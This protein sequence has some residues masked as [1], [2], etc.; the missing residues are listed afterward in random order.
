MRVLLLIAALLVFSQDARAS[1][2]SLSVQCENP[3]KDIFTYYKGVAS[4]KEQ[5][6]DGTM[7]PRKY[8]LVGFDPGLLKA[9]FYTV[10]EPADAVGLIT[11]FEINFANPA[12]IEHRIGP[13]V[14]V[15]FVF[16]GCR[17]IN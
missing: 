14:N 6:T 7:H 9:V 10:Q 13:D 16:K 3:R 12:V 17:R 2:N 5:W 8:D 1:E 11:V 4:G 15:S